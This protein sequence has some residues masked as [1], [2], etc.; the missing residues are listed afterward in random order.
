MAGFA[1]CSA[2]DFR[3]QIGMCAFQTEGIVGLTL[4]SFVPIP[5]MV[6]DAPIGSLLLQ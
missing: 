6:K 5:S 4:I 3:T 2:G 1:F